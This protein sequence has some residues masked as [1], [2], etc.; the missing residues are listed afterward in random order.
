MTQL[1][2]MNRGI[3]DD[4]GDDEEFD[5][6]EGC[7]GSGIRAPAEPSCA[8]ED[9]GPEWF[10]VER[11]D[12]CELFADDLAAALTLAKDAEWIRCGSGG[13]H[14]IARRT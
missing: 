14:V 7:D 6:C 12:Y 11:C 9:R 2:F 8:L 1:V 4:C 5:T 3:H 13:W 10:V